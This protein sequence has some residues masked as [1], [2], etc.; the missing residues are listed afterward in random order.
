MSHI[1]KRKS[2]YY[3]YYYIALTQHTS[4]HV[5]LQIAFL[6]SLQETSGRRAGQ[7]LYTVRRALVE[8]K[9]YQKISASGFLLSDLA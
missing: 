7:S 5:R 6:F 4:L 9:K 3:Y 1:R 8:S 2:Y